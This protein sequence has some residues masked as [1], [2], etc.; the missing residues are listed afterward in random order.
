MVSL[1]RYTPDV[2]LKP[3]SPVAPRVMF[4]IARGLVVATVALASAGCSSVIAVRQPLSESAVA[5]LNDMVGGGHSAE[6][7][8]KPAAGGPNSGI[9]RALDLKLAREVTEL[10]LDEGSAGGV[11][12]QVPTAALR[13]IQSLHRG[14]AGVAG[15]G[16]G[17]AAGVAAG[18]G[19]Y[20]ALLNRSRDE[21]GGGL[22]LVYF[23]LI[24]GTILGIPGAVIGTMIGHSTIIDLDWTKGSHAREPCLTAQIGLVTEDADGT[25]LGCSRVPIDSEQ[26]NWT[27]Q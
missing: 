8:V 17:F 4:S 12:E 23:P 2:L 15:F 27:R 7:L 3:P 9:R 13:Q 19:I 14:G 1:E 26:P 16:L 6:V 10:Q 20:V 22:G 21:A 18:V 11:R 5:E 24:V 25:M